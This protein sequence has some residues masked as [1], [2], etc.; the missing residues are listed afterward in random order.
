M[1]PGKDAPMANRDDR[2]P[3]NVDGK[4]YVDDQCIDCDMCRE[5]AAAHFCREDSGGYSYVHRQPLTP[6]EVTLCREAMEA[7]PVNAIG[8]N[9]DQK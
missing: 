9:G 1:G 6:E 3:E 4:F 5:M 2:W 8:D 7:C